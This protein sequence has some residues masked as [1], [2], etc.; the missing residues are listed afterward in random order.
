MTLNEDQKKQVIQWINAGAKLAEIQGRLEKEF[1]ARVTYM[2]VRFLVDDLKVMPKDPEEKKAATPP[3]KPA[4]RPPTAPNPAAASTPA[5]AIPVEV[6]PEPTSPG[7]AGGVTVTVDSVVR[8]GAMI[9][10]NVTFSDGKS[11][12][13]YLDQMGRLGMAPMEKGYRPLPADVEEF[14]LLLQDELAKKGF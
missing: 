9:S 11:A 8:P 7:G 1:S 5:T 3:A 4:A 14:Q 13:W 12:G 2:E 6:V 10:G